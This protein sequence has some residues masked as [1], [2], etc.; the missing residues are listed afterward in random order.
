M[1]EISLR[2]YRFD[3]AVLLGPRQLIG[4]G[5]SIDRFWIDDGAQF[6]L[7]HGGPLRALPQFDQIP[8]FVGIAA[9]I[10]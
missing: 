8:G 9:E 3:S 5:P 2:G 7:Q 4:L 6:R 10:E 1:R